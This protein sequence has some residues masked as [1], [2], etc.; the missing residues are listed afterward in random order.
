MHLRSEVLKNLD[1][2]RIMYEPAELPL[3]WMT[4]HAI[5]NFNYSDN[6]AESHL[7]G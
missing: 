7:V 6:S 1:L 2:T 3:R 5:G 4:L